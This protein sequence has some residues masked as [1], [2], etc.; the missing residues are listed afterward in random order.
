MS[1][2]LPQCIPAYQEDFPWG[3][4]VGFTLN[5]GCQLKLTKNP[6]KTP[7]FSQKIP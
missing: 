4:P 3:L 5:K 1:L 2:P 6:L 7:D